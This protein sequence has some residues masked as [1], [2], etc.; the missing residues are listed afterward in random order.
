MIL[1][2]SYK[3]TYIAFFQWFLDDSLQR[4][5]DRINYTVNL[6]ESNDRVDARVLLIEFNDV[7]RND[8]AGFVVDNVTRHTRTS[9]NNYTML[10]MIRIRPY[11]NA[12]FSLFYDTLDRS[13]YVY[14]SGGLL[15]TCN[16][17]VTA[18]QTESYR[19]W[20]EAAKLCGR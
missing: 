11:C 6:H 2:L 10:A 13:H 20:S 14:L 1:S 3:R 7:S 19:L 4:C 15:G 18:F 9:H 12:V 5:T 16:F 17:L 8:R